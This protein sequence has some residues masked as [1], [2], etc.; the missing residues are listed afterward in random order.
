MKLIFTGGGT[1]GH[2]YPALSVAEAVSTLAPESEILY[3]GTPTGAE[4]RLVPQQGIPFR[5]IHAGQ[6][7]GKAPWQV[8][9]NLIRLGQG[10]VEARAALRA[11]RPDAVF[12]TGGYASMPV[13]LAARLSGIPIVVF[14]PDVFPGWAVRVGSRLA[15]RVAASTEAPLPLLPREKTEVCGYP[16]RFQ[17]ATANREGARRSLGL[18]HG[19]VLLISGASS[20]SRALNDAVLRNLPVILGDFEVLHLTGVADE[21]RVLRARDALPDALRRRFHVRGF[22]DEMACAMS[23]AD[24]AVMRAGASCLGE[25]AA[26]GLATILVPGPFSDQRRNAEFVASRGAAILLDQSSLATDL[27][28]T[29]RR[30]AA[31][32]QRLAAMRAAAQGL[33][34]PNAADTLATML[35]EA[36][37]LHA[38]PEAR[39]R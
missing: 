20:G 33:A 25:P 18:G 26:A 1:G 13:V 16:L 6:V 34:R 28:P 11:F 23:A 24:L 27:L 38:T 15:T 31:S 2:V 35:I 21:E 22:L 32:P 37:R 9:A 5:G 19:N 10:V 4:R 14:L 39:I 36:A 17:F 7:R 29:L 8:A 3:L 12:A 30:L